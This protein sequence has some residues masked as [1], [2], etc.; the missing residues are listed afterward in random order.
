LNFSRLHKLSLGLAVSLSVLIGSWPAVPTWAET[1]DDLFLA[2][3]SPVDS[4]SWLRRRVIREKD[5]A[6]YGLCFKPPTK[7]QI[8]KP[9]VVVL[10][11]F[12]S[13]PAAVT[14]MVATLS[15]EE[16]RCGYF[17]YANDQ[18][19]ETS[20]RY[21]ASQLHAARRAHPEVRFALVTHSMG[22]VVA[23]RVIEDKKLDAGNVSQ[24]IMVAPPNHGSQL[25]KYAVAVDTWEHWLGRRTGSPWRRWRD[26]VVDGLGEASDELVPGSPFLERLNERP[27]NPDVRYSILLGSDA[28][29][30]RGEM[31][32]LRRSARAMQLVPGAE[33]SAAKLV[34]ALNEFDECV[35]GSG[36]GVVAIKRGRLTGVDDIVVLPFGHLCVTD[37]EHGEQREL[38]QKEVA[39]RLQP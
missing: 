32:W 4:S 16:Y 18:S 19:I 17:G 20:A 38:V 10:H 1:A 15:L 39:K 29:L 9:V 7:Q 35:D 30:S 24:I 26:S 8:E 27:R 33:K 28:S 21:L 37:D 11:G 14:S 13:C 34:E 3:V 12:N 2:N 5:L 6:C 22:G 23:R 36:D 25:A 31:A